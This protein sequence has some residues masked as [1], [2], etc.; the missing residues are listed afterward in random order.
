MNAKNGCG[1]RSIATAVCFFAALLL[2]AAV[3]GEAVGRVHPATL[4]GTDGHQASRGAGS[5]NA[6]GI[7]A[8]GLPADPTHQARKNRYISI[9]PAVNGG[10]QVAY[11][12]T[13]ASMR[14]CSGDL[15]RACAVDGDCVNV[16]ENDNDARCSSPAQCGGAAC[17][18]TGPCV[19]HPDTGRLLGW[20]ETPFQEPLGCPNMTCANDDWIA[21]VGPAPVFQVWTQDTLHIGD[22]VIVPV[23]TYAIE[24]C[25]PPDGASCSSAL[26]IGTIEKPG[27]NK[28]F[29]DVA[30]PVDLSGNYTPPDRLVNVVDFGAYFVTVQHFGTAMLPQAHPTWIDLVGSGPGSPP[31]YIM[32]VEDLDKITFGYGERVYTQ[33]GDFL[34]PAACPNVPAMVPCCLPAGTC[35]EMTPEDCTAAAGTEVCMCLGDSEP[36][37]TDDACE[38]PVDPPAQVLAEDSLATSCTSDTDC[39]NLATCIGGRCYV[40]RNR[41]ISVEPGNAG[42]CMAIR[43]ELTASADFPA[44]TGLQKW[45]GPPDAST[46][47][48]NLQD[49]PEYRDWGADP[50]VIHIGD[51]EIVPVATY[52]VRAIEQSCDTGTP[53]NFSPALTIATTPRP[54][55][56]LWA[57]V[58]GEG[59]AGQ[60]LPP[61]DGFL[62]L[63][64]IRAYLFWFRGDVEAPPLTWLDLAREIPNGSI[65]G[66]DQ[67]AAID[68][69]HGGAYPGIGPCA[70]LMPTA[71]SR[72]TSSEPAVISGN[73]NTGGNPAVEGEGLPRLDCKLFEI[74]AGGTGAP[75]AQDPVTGQY[76]VLPG[77]RVILEIYLLD[78]I[79]VLGAYQTVIAT[80]ADAGSLGSVDLV[81]GEPVDMC[82]VV[83]ELSGVE[84][85]PNHVTAGGQDD[86]V[87]ATAPFGSVDGG[88]S[89]L[90]DQSPT[91]LAAASVF[92]GWPVPPNPPNPPGTPGYFASYALDVHATVGTFSIGLVPE[93]TS[94]PGDDRAAATGTYLLTGSTGP[95]GDSAP[96]SVPERCAELL[97]VMDCNG[98]GIADDC[99]TDQ[100]N[101][102][103]DQ[104][105]CE[106]GE[107]GIAPDCNANAIPDSC[108]IDQGSPAPGGPFYCDPAAPPIGLTECDTDCNVNG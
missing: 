97:V 50:V 66:R 98:N 55:N 39:T 89:C 48:A 24:A 20:V 11:K 75:L 82:P 79:S 12:V 81:C 45:V 102:L 25:L 68:A 88:S 53:A 85:C 78:S 28:N 26:L 106:Q 69:S 46:G 41:Y 67:L 3:A 43:V 10:Q 58:V 92:G 93:P 8:P 40:P 21:R 18:A 27:F 86:F 2:P 56:G 72:D 94:N 34:D 35:A 54:S 57:D 7:V 100:T 80:G 29:G 13:L 77:E 76:R 83:V 19:E 49:L 84:I 99:E 95:F 63:F 6:L 70:P 74:G 38:C 31:N 65:D 61:P 103:C 44:C 96:Y 22:C 60:P 15:R 23:A 62:T 4:E 51:R 104:G 73:N 30:G 107:C 37:G 42:H 16:C 36:N 5:R 59:P 105:L 90:P 64:D 17:V 32:N 71:G 33:D 9:D 52:E 14:R 91:N 108:E 101:A 47:I 87:Y 1:P